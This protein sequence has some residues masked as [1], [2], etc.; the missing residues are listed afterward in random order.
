MELSD[1]RMIQTTLLTFKS[2]LFEVK[3]GVIHEKKNR[4]DKSGRLLQIPEGQYCG[5]LSLVYYRQRGE[6]IVLTCFSFLAHKHLKKNGRHF[7][8]ND[9]HV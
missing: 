9:Y 2:S 3:G 7:T 6:M 4:L 5:G 1:A 8:V